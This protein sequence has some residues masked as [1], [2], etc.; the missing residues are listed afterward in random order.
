MSIDRRLLHTEQAYVDVRT[1][2]WNVP[3]LVLDGK[4]FERL[5]DLEL[6][7]SLRY[8]SFTSLLL[9]EA[10][11][12]KGKF[13]EHTQASLLEKMAQLFRKE[14]R[15]TD[16]I[17]TGE[18]F[19]KVILIHADKHIARRVGERLLSWVSN[20]YGLTEIAG[21]CCFNMGGACFPSHATDTRG[22]L[23]KAGAML[24]R[25]RQHG[26]NHLCVSD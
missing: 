11:Q 12:D 14:L 9:M 25:S 8:Q 7:R 23:Q 21:R 24:E 19:M 17:G 4:L 5:L 10:N 2:Q 20:Y 18:G 15:E 6:K 3:N 26:G 1:E 13:R 16:I 22:L